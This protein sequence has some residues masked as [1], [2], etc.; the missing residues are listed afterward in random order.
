MFSPSH[1]AAGRRRIARAEA[2][3]SV[4]RSRGAF[5]TGRTAPSVGSSSSVAPSPSSSAVRGVGGHRAELHD[6]R[7]AAG[8]RQHGDVARRTAA[9]ER[10]PATPRPVDFKE[11]RWR[12]VVGAHDC[13]IRNFQDRRA[14]AD[15]AASRSDTVAQIRQIGGARLQ[16]FVGRGVIVCDL[17]VAG[18]TTRPRRPAC[19]HGWP[20]KSAR[21]TRRP[22]AAHSETRGYCAAS[23]PAASASAAICRPADTIAARSARSSSSGVPAARPSSA[24][25]RHARTGRGQN[26]STRSCLC[27]TC[28]AAS[29]RMFTGRCPENRWRR[30]RSEPQRPLRRL[31]PTP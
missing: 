11:S 30:D 2:R 7:D 26:R 25:R 27:N 9:Q 28:P 22:Q 12:Q 3:L 15:R 19:R 17:F 13:A 31:P 1:D 29:A 4:M 8:S 18:A 14:V 24:R 5:R 6:H 23:P 10:K 16:V 20:R 21:E